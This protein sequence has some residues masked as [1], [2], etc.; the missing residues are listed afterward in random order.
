[1]I[2]FSDCKDLFMLIKESS[3]TIKYQEDYQNDP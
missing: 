3:E 2:T 1:M